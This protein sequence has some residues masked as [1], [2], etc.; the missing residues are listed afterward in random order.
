MTVSAQ[1]QVDIAIVG[2]GM[3]GLALAAALAD[4]DVSILLIDAA[5]APAQTEPLT[6]AQNREQGR[7]PPPS[8]T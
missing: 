1:Q 3:V 8:A 7:L 2:A 4:C 6:R 5:E